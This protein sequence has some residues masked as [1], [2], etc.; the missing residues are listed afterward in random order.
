[1]AKE[2]TE[3]TELTAAGQLRI[4]TV[5]PFNLLKYGFKRTYCGANVLFEIEF[6]NIRG[7]NNVTDY[8]TAE[9]AE[10]ARSAQRVLSL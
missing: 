9:G 4:Y 1:V 5:F 3:V 10:K 2:W 7:G 6:G 8:L